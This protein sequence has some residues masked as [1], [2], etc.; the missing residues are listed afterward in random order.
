MNSEFWA[1]LALK[2]RFYFIRFSFTSLPFFLFVV[3][4]TFKMP[5]SV[6]TGFNDCALR[7]FFFNTT[8]F[9][10]CCTCVRNECA[11]HTWLHMYGGFDFTLLYCF[12]SQHIHFCP[13]PLVY[14][15]SLLS[16]V[17]CEAS[18]RELKQLNSFYLSLA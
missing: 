1:V 8:D 12:Q 6:C 14:L 5:S 15:V 4:H 17:Q 2:I 7:T 3:S 13:F 9:N 18:Q 16:F 10:T 11:L